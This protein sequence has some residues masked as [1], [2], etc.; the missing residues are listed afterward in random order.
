[1]IQTEND[2]TGPWCGATFIAAQWAVTAAHCVVAERR[3]AASSAWC[4]AA[5]S[6]TARTARRSMSRRSFVTRLTATRRTRTTSPCFASRSPS[7]AQAGAPR[8]EGGVAEA[9]RAGHQRDRDRL[10]R[11]E[12]GRPAVE[13]AAPGHGPDRG[14]RARNQQYRGIIDERQVCAG[15]RA[16]ART[17]ARA[18]AAARSSRRSTASTCRSAS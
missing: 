11:D 9:L 8:D 10:G 13:H 17:P 3:A 15:L 7:D 18:T 2:E 5:S 14:A 12:R 1:M 16:A 6:R 4:S